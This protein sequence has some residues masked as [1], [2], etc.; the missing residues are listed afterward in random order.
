[1]GTFTDIAGIANAASS[2]AGTVEDVAKEINSSAVGLQRGLGSISRASSKSI[3]Y[4]PILI[5]NNI[6]PK[7]MGLVAKNLEGSYTSFVSACFALAPAM[8]VKNS[9]M[10]N[11]EDYL[12]LFHQNIGLQT[13]GDLMVSLR[14]TMEEFKM[15]PN[16][17]LNEV[18]VSD[19][20]N[21]IKRTVGDKNDNNRVQVVDKA[22]INKVTNE[23]NSF[24]PS[25]VEVKVTFIIGG[26][27]VDVNIPVGVKCVMH[28]VAADELNDHIM[29]SVAGKGLLHNLIRYTTGE[30]HSLSDILFGTSKMKRNISKNSDVS[31]WLDALDHRK[32]M[33]KIRNVIPFLAKQPYLP[34]M[35]IMI[36]LEDVKE[37]ERQTGYNI[38]SD[39][40]RAVKFMRD[41]FLLTLAIVDDVTET[42]YIM[43]DGHDNY[44]EY[45]FSY[46]KKENSKNEDIVNALIKGIGMS[47]GRGI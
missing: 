9:D 22:Q 25:V 26:K 15:F 39:E 30:L 2:V 41:N 38:L 34:N 32:R 16:E 23:G 31:K 36:S 19:I 40:R 27:D 46:I 3:Y 12:K 20:A 33:N 44:Q 37:I 4:F 17:P 45:P 18:S 11:V 24:R 47:A 42:A 8:N 5:S 43:Y 29:E 6:N 7:S 28:P 14:E 1:M 13:K 10:V 21:S 35:S